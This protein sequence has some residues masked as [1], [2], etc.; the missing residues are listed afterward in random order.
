M[1]RVYLHIGINKA[2]STSLQSWCLSNRDQLAGQAGLLYPRCGLVGG[3]H[4][5]LSEA[6]GFSLTGVP[7][8]NLAQF[9]QALAAE[10]R[11]S[12]CCRVLLSS[13]DFVFDQ[14]P[15]RVAELLDGFE[16][17]ILVY[18]RRH[19]HWWESAYKQA[20]TMT[21]KPEWTPGIEGYIEHNRRRHSWYGDFRHLLDRW[22][23][24]FGQERMIV[25]PF[26]SKQLQQG[27]ARDAMGAIGIDPSLLA[28]CQPE[29]ALNKALSNR[30]CAVLEIAQRSGMTPAEIEQVLAHLR[31]HDEPADEPSLISPQL[32]RALLDRHRRDYDYITATYLS[33]PQTEL[34]LEAG[35]PSDDDWTPPQPVLAEEVVTEIVTALRTSRE[36]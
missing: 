12:G 24:V 29:R 31:R 20:L 21:R 26:E 3:A 7:D 14:N 16:V 25:R 36:P 6:T 28:G 22:S 34:F 15:G 33:A 1:T 4:Y 27:I 13:E 35:D 23:G 30:A 19:D 2:G 8:P 18:L 17:G 32:R 10:I 9:R 11:D 5:G